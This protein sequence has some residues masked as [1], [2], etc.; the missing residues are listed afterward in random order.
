MTE[1]SVELFDKLLESIIENSEITPDRIVILNLS[2]K[3]MSE[4]ITPARIELIKIIKEKS[5]ESVNEL[6]KLTNRPLESI[7]RDLRVLNNYGILEFVRIGKT[8]KPIIEKDM[9]LIP[10]IK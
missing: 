2:K 4:I 6:V 9:I 10:L 8:K 1:K 5:P 3:K 7:S